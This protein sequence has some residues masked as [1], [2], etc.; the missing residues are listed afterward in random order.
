MFGL[1]F[2]DTLLLIGGPLVGAAVVLLALRLFAGK[3]AE[4]KI[5]SEV[6]AERVR[7]VGKLVGLEVCAK[8]IA[9]A[10]TGLSWMPPLLLSQ[11]KVAMIFHFERQYFVDLSEIQRHDVHKIEPGRYRLTLPPVKGDLRLTDVTPYDIQSGRV[12]GLLDVIQMNAQRQKDLMMR[13]QEQAA[14]LYTSG[15]ARYKSDARASIERQLRTLFALF[16]A[17]VEMV[18]PGEAPAQH[19]AG[20]EPR[21]YAESGPARS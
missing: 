10:T 21:T 8:E 6:I 9:T 17:E 19:R 2:F 16:D 4:T 15:D 18:W 11:A 20:A 1:S 13:A 5:E 7:S 14:M 3:A 12:L